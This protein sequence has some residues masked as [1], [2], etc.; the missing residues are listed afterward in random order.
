VSVTVELKSAI[1]P[2]ECL[3]E[4]MTAYQGLC[5]VRVI[6]ESPAGH[7]IEISRA[8]EAID[9]EQLTNEFLNYL[10]D[11]SLEKHLAE[12]ENGNGTDRISAP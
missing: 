2:P 6:S 4:A 3:R 11:L 5:S 12:F 1:Y 10:L 8:S 7:S 9:E